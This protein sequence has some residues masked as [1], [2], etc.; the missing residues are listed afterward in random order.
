MKAISG[1]GARINC[2]QARSFF[3]SF[4]SSRPLSPVLLVCTRHTLPDPPIDLPTRPSSAY[5]FPEYPHSERESALDQTKRRTLSR[6]AVAPTPRSDVTARQLVRFRIPGTCPRSRFGTARLLEGLRVTD[7]RFHT[8][9]FAERWS[10]CHALRAGCHR[11]RDGRARRPSRD[12][13]SRRG[14]RC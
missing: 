2:A 6:H 1:P 5:P 4:S 11:L 8:R 7:Y 9:G 3:F 10:V 14:W 12:G 13:L